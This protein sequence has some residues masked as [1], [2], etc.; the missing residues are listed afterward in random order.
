MAI[1]P[2][3]S[4]TL[5]RPP[6]HLLPLA[7]LTW[8]A[9]V[10]L[11]YVRAAIDAFG[12]DGFTGAR[13]ARDEIVVM[14]AI[15][16]TAL[17][18]SAVI[19]RARRWLLGPIVCLAF[20]AGAMVLAWTAG[21][22]GALVASGMLLAW[23]WSMGCAALRAMGVRAPL[24]GAVAHFAL[25]VGAGMAVLSFL[26][27]GLALVG[28]VGD[29]TLALLLLVG[30]L[31]LVSNLRELEIEARSYRLPALDFGEQ[32]ALVGL[33]GASLIGLA[34]CLTPQT[35]FDALHYH[36]AL[37]R[38]VLETGS[39][40]ERPD[41]I[42]SYFPL[43]MEMVYVPSFWLGGEAAANL[44]HW[45]FAP[46]TAALLWG[47]GDRLFGRPAGALA[48]ALFGLMPL[49]VWEST[50]VT[51]DLPM[52]FFAVAAVYLMLLRTSSGREI[53]GAAGLCAGLALAFKVVAAI[54]ILPLAL[55]F[56]ASVLL[57][58]RRAE[59]R[60]VALP[61]V[62]F[63]LGGLIGGAPWLL[64][65]L[66]QVGNPVLPLLNNVFKSD[67][68]PHVDERFDLDQ[69]GVGTSVS[70]LVSVWWQASADPS[71]FGQATPDWVIGVVLLA[72]VGLLLLLVPAIW[73]ARRA[74]GAVNGHQGTPWVGPGAHERMTAVWL[75]AAGASL[76]A[77]FFLS[78]YLRY[79]L[80]AFALLAPPGAW[81]LVE[82]LR[83]IDRPD[84]AALAPGVAVAV[85]GASGAVITVA[86]FS[87]TP[88]H[89]PTNVLLGRETAAEYRE[90]WIPNRGAI[91]FFDEVTRGTD[92]SGVILGFPYN[93]FASNRLYDV[94]VPGTLSPFRRIVDAGLT[95][96]ETSTRLVEANV[97]WLI[98]DSNNPFVAP[99]WPPDW[100][101][102]SVLSA[103]FIAGYTEVAFEENGVFV[104]RIV[105][106]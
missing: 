64:L 29:I 38:Y 31:P 94:I 77:W 58:K 22:A 39:F 90:R 71:R 5:P 45:A 82:A 96:D 27:L 23:C 80:P 21:Q 55:A 87:L 37:P 66:V 43:G 93:Y 79:G 20:G 35:N 41:I 1:K 52:T 16:A 100:L 24:M 98:Y 101:A 60:E 50:A 4:H 7:A 91:A 75:V 47:A 102:E 85:L 99:E 3:G 36:L 89:F 68:W 40:V 15:A 61:V 14:L 84:I 106:P 2:A 81:A 83:R 78:Q 6:T 17:L 26:V 105:A 34:V 32:A 13:A 67:R 72:P 70:D 44:M 18:V 65:R 19:W 59:S 33:A 86:A 63:A 56:A 54:Y 88:E 30:L 103:A 9:F 104:Y 11:L 74:E 95:F 25:S 46:L 62:R 97:R 49:V 10:G 76:L 69:F 8:L 57:S 51:S 92:E 53:G 73:P 12:R 48:A 28:L 42:Q